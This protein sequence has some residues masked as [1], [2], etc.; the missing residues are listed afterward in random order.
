MSVRTA[1][2][3]C[4]CLLATACEPPNVAPNQGDTTAP[5]PEPATV[6]PPPADPVRRATA[7]PGPAA[8]AWRA[9]GAMAVTPKHVL[10]A[11]SH[12]ERLVLV[13]RET[14]HV[15][16][17]QLL[18]LPEQVVVGPAGF[19]YVSLHRA[20]AVAK[21]DLGARVEIARTVVGAGAW[22]LALDER[23]QRLYVSTTF[24]GDVLAIATETMEVT[25]AAT[26]WDQP[27]ALA[28]GDGFIAVTQRGQLAAR[29][30]VDAA[31]D[32]TE[33]LDWSPLRASTPQAEAAIQARGLPT[34]DTTATPGLALATVIHPTS[35]LPLTAHQLAYT[36]TVQSATVAPPSDFYYSNEGTVGFH[37][38]VSHGSSGGSSLAPASSQMGMEQLLLLPRAMAHHPHTHLLAVAGFASDTV[39]FFDTGATDPHDAPLG[40]L[41]VGA[42]PK[43]VAF[44][45]NGASLY[46]FN[47]LGGSVYRYPVSVLSA[48]AQQQWLTS[49]RPDQ[50]IVI[51]DGGRWQRAR[52]AFSS[53]TTG[54][55]RWACVNCHFD[56]LNDGLTWIGLNGVRQTPVLA[57]RVAG[58]APYN[59]KGTEQTL[60]GN[61]NRTLGNLGGTMAPEDVAIVATWLQQLPGPPVP[62]Q[63]AAGDNEAGRLVFEDPSVGCASCHA[64]ERLTNG[65][66]YDVG[67]LSEE[68][69]ALEATLF[70]RGLRTDADFGV[71]DT[72]SLVGL[73][74]S[75]PYMHDGSAATLDDVLDGPMAPKRALTITERGDLIAY[76]RTL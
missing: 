75:A 32:L 49:H 23:T 7:L 25:S 47:E 5:Q 48:G 67:S 54:R 74:H 71:L 11:D 70:D 66:A 63:G 65:A 51:G 6:Q 3:L 56:G 42:G 52:R 37:S 45:P 40:T 30:G 33:V 31:G 8:P 17:L 34:A 27:R 59:W 4:L 41:S 21:I 29:L 50:T 22:G 15:D 72:P 10:V 19:A 39:Q 12:D 55:Q 2:L 69:Y 9:G 58:T 43:A 38:G 1:T 24:E 28:V 20:G 57:G 73:G 13:D 18:G 16:A 60:E 62:G 44:S 35:G 36:G 53:A 61:I 64:G 46:V 26:G 76:L 68:E 14:A